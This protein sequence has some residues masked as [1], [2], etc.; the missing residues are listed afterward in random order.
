[1]R[2]KIFSLM[3]VLTMAASFV[4]C[5][6]DKNTD[7]EKKVSTVNREM[8]A[9]EYA[10]FI[11]E[12]ANE[13]KNYITLGQ[14]KNRDIDDVDIAEYTVT[15]ESVDDYIQKLLSSTAT[16]REVTEGV[17][18]KGDTIKLDYSGKLNGE[19]FSG[20]TATNA[21]YV[22]G[23]GGFIS[24]LDEGLAGLTVGQEYDIPCTFPANYGTSTLAGK[25]VIF[26]VKVLSI[27]VQDVPELTDE[28]VAE[29]AEP[30][31]LSGS[32]VEE[33]KK[34]VN[35]Y[36]VKTA[37][38]A[39]VSARYASIYSKLKEEMEVTDYPSEELEYTKNTIDENIK[40]EFNSNASLYGISD[41]VVYV[42]SFYYEF[43]DCTTMD[44]YNKVV[45]DTAKE[46]LFEKMM[47]F[48]VAEE[49]G[50]TVSEEEIMQ[51]G[52]EVAELYEYENFD[53]IIAQFGKEM[54]CEAGYEV[55]CDKVV[56]FISENNN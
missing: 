27:Q 28:W 40:T 2:K 48:M 7:K 36:L 38:E 33:F 41:L 53:A 20:G 23:S 25:D 46:F 13:Y 4:A 55:L 30:A 14:Y 39:L 49:N 24:D 9:S 54:I 52:E 34:A 44:D 29:Y 56:R 22:I 10:D 15:D 17:T 50:I 26:T 1:M 42:S 32:N 43:A 47:I 18:K 37:D 12:C 45:E 6:K 3:L 35:D 16:S 51:K 8:E 19:A 11:V 31:G 21:S 5:G